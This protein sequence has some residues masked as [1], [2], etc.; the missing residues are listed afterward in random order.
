MKGLLSYQA[1]DSLLHRL[2]PLTKLLLAVMLCAASF[3]SASHLFL[4]GLIAL[5][6]LMGWSAGIFKQTAAVLTKLTGL[7]VLMFLLQLLFIREGTPLLTL[8]GFT[9][10]GKAVYFGSLMVM[11]LIAATIPLTIMLSVTQTNDLSNVL[12]QKL[13]LPYQY[14]FTIAT[15][16]R[17]I[18][19]FSEEMAGIIEAQT[20]RGVEFD[21][22]NIFKKLSLILPLCAPLLISS[23]KK[24]DT[25][26]IAAEIRGFHLRQRA[27]SYRQYAFSTADWLVLTGAV[28]LPVAALLVNTLV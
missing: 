4:L 5:N 3:V 6:L 15:A 17:F 27:S 13:H 8:F 2:D 11:R 22:K 16:I 9:I 25:C 1:G 14:A 7:S 26:A 28:L 19:F 10:T 21:T 12:V 24:T 18:P 20:A 23:V